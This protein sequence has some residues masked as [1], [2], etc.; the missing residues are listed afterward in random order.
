[1]Q[2]MVEICWNPP[3]MILIGALFSIKHCMV[4]EICAKLQHPKCKSWIFQHANCF[5]PPRTVR[6]WR[7]HRGDSCP[8]WGQHFLMVHLRQRKTSASA[9]FTHSHAFTMKEYVSHVGLSMGYTMVYLKIVLLKGNMTDWTSDSG[10]IHGASQDVKEI[11]G[12]WVSTNLRPQGD[13]H[14]Y[15][16]PAFTVLFLIYSIYIYIYLY[17]IR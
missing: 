6:R 3:E 14:I 4:C 17:D 2:D 8:N 9:A 12:W 13:W 1:M 10:V 5:E 11:A 15:F 16:K 7:S